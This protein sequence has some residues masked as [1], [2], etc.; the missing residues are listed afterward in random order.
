[1]LMDINTLDWSDKMLSEYKIHKSWLPTI[2]KDS[3]GKF[4]AVSSSLI[5]ELNGVPITGVL[6][7]Q[8]ASCLGHILKEGQV[9]NTYGTGCFM[10][11]NTG[12]NA[13][14]SNHGLLTT[15]CYRVNGN[16]QYALEGAVEI[17]GAA[18]Q[19]AKSVGFIASPKELEPLAS[20]V[21]D[22][23][24]VYFVPAFQGIFSPYWRDD[25]RGL[26]IGFGSNTKRE[27]LAR[28]ILE[29]PCLRTAEVVKAMREDSGK[30][31]TSMAVDGGMTVNNFMMQLQANFMNATIIRKQEQ[32]ITCI[33]AAIAAGLGVK[34]WT[35]LADIEDKIK[36]DKEFKPQM[37]EEDRQKKMDRW[38]QAVQKS[39]GFGWAE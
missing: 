3:N 37:S 7:D 39:I 27:H 11:Q 20:S 19:W 17:A 24:D 30:N 38:S 33:G 12:A 32:E 22:C 36:V 25:A 9:K 1:M 8:H 28:S 34:Y 23:G 4:G 2:I 26:W 15:I 10:L 21:E 35:S 31:V 14:Q 16:T 5:P 6:G 18:I 13:V 29:A